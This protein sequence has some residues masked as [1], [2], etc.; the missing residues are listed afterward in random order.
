MVHQE[1]SGD[2][3]TLLLQAQLTQRARSLAPLEADT[4]Y[5]PRK[6]GFQL[7]QLLQGKG[8]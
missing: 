6:S 4:K 1:H 5:K 8:S 2:A 3:G 7:L